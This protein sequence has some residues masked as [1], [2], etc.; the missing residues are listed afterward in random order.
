M[1]HILNIELTNYCNGHCPVCLRQQYIGQPYYH[2]DYD[3]L[4]KNLTPTLL[5]T[6]HHITFYGASGDPSLYP[7]LYDLIKYLKENNVI[8]EFTSNGD[9]RDDNW[10]ANIFSLLD[11]NDTVGLCLDGDTPEI[12]KLYRGTDF[13]NVFRR[14]ELLN[15]YDVYKT[16]LSILFDYNADSLFRL[17]TLLKE[18]FPNI[19]H[20][21]KST[22]TQFGNFKYPT[23]E[24]ISKVIDNND[25]SYDDPV[26]IVGCDTGYYINADGT[27]TPCCFI[28]TRNRELS[29]YIKQDGL[30]SETY[31]SQKKK[32]NIYDNS[33]SD[34]L[35]NGFYTIIPRFRRILNTCKQCVR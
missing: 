35:N 8:I 33:L 20:T 21:I 30:I 13:N 18:K 25:T 9:T 27:V 22:H 19:R 15:Q 1:K 10:W 14:I 5:K 11:I 23:P 17:N 31:K 24:Q 34:I 12:H 29:Q 26:Y 2:L 3:T 4:I 28:N 16:V 6:F 32:M 7:R